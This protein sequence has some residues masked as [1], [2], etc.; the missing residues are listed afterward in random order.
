LALKIL[1]HEILVMYS[2]PL[3]FGQFTRFIGA[4]NEYG[5]QLICHI[6]HCMETP[7]IGRK[8]K[9]AAIFNG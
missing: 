5:Q 8:K 7:K 9:K 3:F 4:R 2:G 1:I 6:E